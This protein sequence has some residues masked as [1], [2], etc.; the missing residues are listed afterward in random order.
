MTTSLMD[1]VAVVAGA[2]RGAGK[3]IALALGEAGATVYVAGRT[4]RTS[5]PRADGLPGTVEDTA[6]EVTKLGGKGI[7]VQTDC[8]NEEAVAALFDHVER[9]QG[10]LDVLANAVSGGG[11]AYPTLEFWMEQMKRPFWEHD[12]SLWHYNM[13]AGPYAY[14]LATCHAARIM[15]KDRRGLI[16]GVT[17]FIHADASED[18]LLARDMGAYDTGGMMLPDLAHVCINR[19]MRAMSVEL[20]KYN[21]AAITLMPGFMQTEAVLQV[22]TTDELKKQYRFDLSES[23]RYIGRGVAALTADPNVI[24]KTGRIH[25][26]AD[27]AKE[28]GF[29][30]VDGR[31]IPR[32]NA[33]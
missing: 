4:S 25:F 17:D 18:V 29:T 10:R 28:Y 1:K 3:G 20:E 12:L 27:L 23:P 7:A 14:Y 11:D 15:A 33:M 16:V 30:D 26:V 22:M 9:E 2:S 21:I 6:E 8:T 24:A 31:Y 13:M 5:P 19:L 32:F